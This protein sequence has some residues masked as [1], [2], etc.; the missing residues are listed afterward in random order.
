[1]VMYG[2]IILLAH[3]HIAVSLKCYTYSSEHM[4]SRK[5][6]Q[7]APYCTFTMT[8]RCRSGSYAEGAPWSLKRMKDGCKILRE[9]VFSCTCSSK[10]YC[11][12]DRKLIMD[13]W[14]KSPQYQE[15]SIFTS[16]LKSLAEVQTK[17]KTDSSRSKFQHDEDDDTGMFDYDFSKSRK[18]KKCTFNKIQNYF[19]V[20]F[21]TINAAQL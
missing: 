7:N 16:C 17:N 2:L 13:I 21:V 20:L 5:T 6:L 8:S 10:D 4:L 1:M 19:T 11:S 9:K 14:K 15:K 3:I 18:K 12:S